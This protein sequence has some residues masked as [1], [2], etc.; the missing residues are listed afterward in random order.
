MLLIVSVLEKE[1][2][3]QEICLEWGFASTSFNLILLSFQNCE[4]QDTQLHNEPSRF[5][6][7]IALLLLADFDQY[8]LC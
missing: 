2:I 3:E 8:F 4:A 1:A 6:D 7:L 5:N